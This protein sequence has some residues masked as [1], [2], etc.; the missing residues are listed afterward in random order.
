MIEVFRTNVK[1]K[2]EAK[3]VLKHLSDQFP[4]ASLSLDLE[5]CEKILRMERQGQGFDAQEVIET[6]RQQGFECEILED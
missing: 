4:S 2:A 1:K 6:I 5:D 3:R